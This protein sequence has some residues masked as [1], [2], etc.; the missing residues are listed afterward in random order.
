M[1]RVFK[2]KISQ[3][4][5]KEKKLRPFLFSSVVDMDQTASKKS[6]DFGHLPVS[7]WRTQKESPTSR[8]SPNWRRGPIL[9]RVGA[10]E[11][12]YLKL[13]D[14]GVTFSFWVGPPLFLCFC[15]LSE[16]RIIFLK[17]KFQIGP[18]MPHHHPKEQK[19]HPEL[20]V[21]LSS[22][23]ARAKSCRARDPQAD[24]K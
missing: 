11:N 22:V 7:H 19:K 21:G 20:Y 4:E 2:K 12:Q 6:L 8:A 5:A 23:E 17:T 10:F 3:I 1:R 24:E 13:F 15:F 9:T 18:Q 14:F 16:N